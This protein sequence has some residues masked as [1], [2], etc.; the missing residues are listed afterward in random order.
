M[1]FCP[2]IYYSRWTNNYRKALFQDDNNVYV[3]L[4]YL[5]GG[6]LFS[7]LRRAEK[8][9]EELAKFYV[10]EIASALGVLTS[11]HIVYRDLKPENVMLGEIWH[12]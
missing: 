10:A 2:H 3:L 1:L 12:V 9:D 11:L 8:F 7:H 6:E 5:Q 4:E